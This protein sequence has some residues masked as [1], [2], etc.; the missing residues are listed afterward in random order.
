MSWRSDGT[1]YKDRPRPRLLTIVLTIVPRWRPYLIWESIPHIVRDHPLIPPYTPA[2]IQP[3]SSPRSAP[4]RPPRSTIR[5]PSLTELPRCLPAC[6]PP[7]LP[8]PRPVKVRADTS[9]RIEGLF[10]FF[11]PF[12]IL[13]ILLSIIVSIIKNIFEQY[14]TISLDKFAKYL[15]KVKLYEFSSRKCLKREGTT[16]KWRNIYAPFF[17]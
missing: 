5:R 7:C 3:S 9:L 14:H 6:L 15:K 13:Y 11:L 8:P 16:S 4:P 1:G 17:C 2:L 10:P 12:F